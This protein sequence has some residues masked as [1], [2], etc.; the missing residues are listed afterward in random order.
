MQWCACS[1]F[2]HREVFIG[3]LG[4][5]SDLGEAVTHQVAAGQVE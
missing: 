1:D 3:L 2:Q 5:F 4:S